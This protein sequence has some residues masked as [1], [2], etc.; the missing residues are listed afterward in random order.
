MIHTFLHKT[1][2]S[3][4]LFKRT[5]NDITKAK[6]ISRYLKKRNS[7]LSKEKSKTSYHYIRKG[8]IAFICFMLLKVPFK[9]A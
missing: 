5:F 6:V 4:A 8:Q 1:V 2:K 3:T 9:R 7:S